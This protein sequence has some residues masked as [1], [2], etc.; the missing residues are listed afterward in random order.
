MFRPM[1]FEQYYYHAYRSNGYDVSPEPVEKVA[2]AQNV[3]PVL[4]KLAKAVFDQTRLD[5]IPY[6]TPQ[7]RLADAF[8]VAQAF[9]AHV[10]ECKKTASTVAVGLV[11]HLLDAAKKYAEAHRLSIEPAEAL[12]LAAVTIEESEASVPYPGAEKLI[13]LV[14]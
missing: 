13:E 10:E 8:K 5:G 11:D 2:A 7:Q 12:K 1:T 6:E 3:D 14:G 4:A 9:V